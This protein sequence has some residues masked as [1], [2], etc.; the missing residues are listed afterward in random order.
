MIVIINIKIFTKIALYNQRIRYFHILTPNNLTRRHLY[1][2]RNSL[3][4][5]ELKNAETLNGIRTHD[6]SVR[7]AVCVSDYVATAYLNSCVKGKNCLKTAV[8]KRLHSG[9][10]AKL[11]AS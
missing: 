7:V 3:S 10:A 1:N 6:P 8:R 11:N 9:I 2:Y 5:E 4:Y